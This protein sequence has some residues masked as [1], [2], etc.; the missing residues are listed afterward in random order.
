MD[1]TTA[2]RTLGLTPPVTWTEARSAWRRAASRYHPDRGGANPAKFC[3]AKD[4]WE[5]LDA[6]LSR[7]GGPSKVPLSGEPLPELNLGTPL[8]LRELRL[9]GVRIPSAVGT[10]RLVLADEVLLQVD[11]ETPIP[12]LG[13]RFEATVLHAGV[14]AVSLRGPI[15]SSAYTKGVPQKIAAFWVRPVFGPR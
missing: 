6:E 14:V 2:Y 11:L 12:R 1:I 10:A 13:S 5:I 4:A 9:D 7:G 3:A 8:T 15:V